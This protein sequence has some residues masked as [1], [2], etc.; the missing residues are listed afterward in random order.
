MVTI[1]ASGTV[2]IGLPAF[3]LRS[4]VARHT[5]SSDIERGR[6]GYIR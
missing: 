1:G 3:S 4:C 6:Y 5:Q 2:T